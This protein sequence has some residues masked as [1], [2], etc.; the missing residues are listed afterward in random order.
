MGREM[1]IKRGG[2]GGAIGNW[3]HM[4]KEIIGNGS[5]SN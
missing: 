4:A 3:P 2:G 1:Q 5:V